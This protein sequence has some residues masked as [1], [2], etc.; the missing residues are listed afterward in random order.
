MAGRHADT[1]PEPRAVEPPGVPQRPIDV[2]LSA[3][4]AVLAAALPLLAGPAAPPAE[5]PVAPTTAGPN[6]LSGPSGPSGQV[7]SSGLSGFADCEALRRWYVDAAL[8]TVGPWGWNVPMVYDAVATA[9]RADGTADAAVGNGATGTNVQEAGVDEPDVAKTD[10]SVLVRVLGRR[11][12]VVDVSGERPRELSRIRLPGNHIYDTELL[13]VGT[14]VLALSTEGGGYGSRITF[15]DGGSVGGRTHVTH[16]DITDPAEPV[17]RSHQRVDGTLV[18]SREYGDGTVRLVVSTGLPELDFVHPTS[19][20]RLAEARR[21]NRAIVRATPVE[22]WLPGIRQGDGRGRHRLLDC[23]SVLHPARSA[24]FGTLSV[25]TL[26]TSAPRSVEATGILAAGDLA[27]SSADRLYVATLDQP[28][29][30]D[31][32]LRGN[33]VLDKPPSTEVHA[34]GLDGTA[35]T[36]LA[37][38]RL[39]GTVRDRWSFSEHDGVLRVATA[40]GRGWQPRENAVQTLVE[41]DGRLVRVGRVDG[42]GPREHIQS[43]RWLGDLAVVVTFRQVDPLYTLDLSDPSAPRVLGALKIPGFSGYLHPLGDDLLLGLGE[44]ATRRGRSLGAQAAVFDL[45]DLADVRRASAARFGRLDRFAVAWESRAFTY[46]PDHRVV[47]ASLESWGRYGGS[48]LVALRVGEAG[49]L[50]PAGSWPA[51]RWNASAVRALP[52]AEGRV[53]LVRPGDRPVRVLDL[54]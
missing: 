50:T 44:H 15:Q 33:G 3:R 42:L 22:T 17:V 4:A 5:P 1:V 12:V 37:S 25:L 28:W 16:V 31:V 32:V 13:L 45:T 24:G 39:P 6:E 18:A 52:L 14:D 2:H 46:L 35:T 51:G 47:L 21:L 40:L 49:S 27:Y 36:Y 8:P 53:A 7:T 20:R 10:G 26:P 41:R 29:W 34:F 11:L 23:T 48:R 38:G 43:V 30:D 54:D 9:V 19:K